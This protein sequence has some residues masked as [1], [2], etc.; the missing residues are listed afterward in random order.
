MAPKS[1]LKIAVIGA[2]SEQFSAGIISDVLLSDALSGGELNL[3]LMDVKADRLAAPQRYAQTAAAHLHRHANVITTTALSEAVAD[4]DYVVTAIEVKRYLYWA[5]DFHIPR[6]YGFPQIYG[7]NGG[8]GGLF[9]ALRNFGPMLEIAHTM[10]RL[11]P[12]A[13]LINYTNPEAKLV[14]AISSLTKIKSIGMCH[15]VFMGIDQLSR[16]LEIPAEEID[17]VACGLNHFA[18]YQQIRRKRTG[19]DLYPLL[20]ERERQANWLAAWDE[21][22]LS[23][24]LFRT[25]G[26]WPYPG[27]NH[28]GEYLRWSS[29]FMACTNMQYFYDPV[30]ENPWETMEPPT[31]VYDLGGKPAETPLFDPDA[32]KQLYP[33]FEK[34]TMSVEAGVFPSGEEAVLILDAFAGG[35]RRPIATVNVPNRGT[36]PDLPDDMV[37]EVPAIADTDGLHLPSLPPLPTGITTM[38]Q[39]QGNINRILVEAYA[40]R[41]RRKLLQALLIDPTVSTYANAVALIDEMFTRQQ[42]LLPEMDW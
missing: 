1:S 25:F 29:E 4:A 19:E 39:L 17:V 2:G 24:I 10:E 16:L 15:G 30:A 23:R 40:E 33:A 6:K 12:D 13:W 22:A 34:R 20:R 14:Q 28:S 31:F 42:P 9:H 21:L 18:W 3:A 8:P 5:Q 26:L 35:G 38:L 11:C 32:S 36:I 27:T 7:E 41:S 37:V